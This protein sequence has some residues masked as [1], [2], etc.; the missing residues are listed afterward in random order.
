MIYVILIISLLLE[1][2]I[3]NIIS[4]N[5][6]FNPLFLIISLGLLYPYLKKDSTK[7]LIICSISGLIYDTIFYNSIFLNTI[8]FF[9]LGLI[10]I[11][12]NKYLSKNILNSVII[13]IIVITLYRLISYSILCI[14]GYTSFN[15]MIL[16]K[17]IYTSL[18][19]NIIYE[20]IL[21]NVL[22]RIKNMI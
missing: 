21:Y 12:L 22:K 10:I 17:S 1:C 20:I 8:S 3:S 16:L 2:A 11:L 5:S 15:I 14:I 4:L 18:I 13:S 7:Y 6:I 9:I 19:I